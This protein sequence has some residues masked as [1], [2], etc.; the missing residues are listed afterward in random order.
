MFTWEKTKMMWQIQR[1]VDKAPGPGPP[2][3]MSSELSVWAEVTGTAQGQLPS[4]ISFLILLPLPIADWGERR[5]EDF[6]ST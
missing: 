3:D 2:W 6:T 1:K 4:I 5:G